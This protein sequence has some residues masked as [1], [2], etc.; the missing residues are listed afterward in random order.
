MS[1][2]CGCSASGQR[3]AEVQA[4]MQHSRLRARYVSVLF[5]IPVSYTH[6]QN[7]VVLRIAPC[8]GSVGIG[9]GGAGGSVIG[10]KG[11]NTQSGSS[12][13]GLIV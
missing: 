4:Q 8:C 10:G 9:N 11:E 6:L 5:F 3:S 2:M 1:V 12:T 7:S 13:A